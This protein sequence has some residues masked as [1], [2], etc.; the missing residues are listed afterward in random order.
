MKLVILLLLSTIS[1]FFCK[2][3]ETE[4]VTGDTAIIPLPVQLQTQPGFF[5]IDSQTS[6]QSDSFPNTT[7]DP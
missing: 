7:F 3:Q 5:T 6:I 4:V 2:Q 1:L